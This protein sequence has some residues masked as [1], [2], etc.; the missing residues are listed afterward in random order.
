M[1]LEIIFYAQGSVNQTIKITDASLTEQQ[2][3]QGLRDGSILTSI[4]DGDV[5]RFTDGDMKKIGHVVDTSAGDDMEYDF[6]LGDEE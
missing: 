4:G 3:K 5:V 2:V 1:N 6:D